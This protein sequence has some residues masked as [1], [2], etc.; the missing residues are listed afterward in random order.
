MLR[1]K[2][3][4]NP[5]TGMPRFSKRGGEDGAFNEGEVI[6]LRRKRKPS[7]IQ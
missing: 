3:G 2:V 6:C 7:G 4:L 5:T 1:V